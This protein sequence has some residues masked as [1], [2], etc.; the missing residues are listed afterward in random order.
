MNNYE[1]YFRA[2]VSEKQKSGQTPNGTCQKISEKRYQC[3]PL[4]SENKLLEKK[5]ALT[6]A[7]RDTAIQPLLMDVGK[8]RKTL[9]FW[10]DERALTWPDTGNFCAYFREYVNRYYLVTFQFYSVIRSLLCVFFLSRAL[11]LRQHKGKLHVRVPW[12]LKFW[13]ERDAKYLQ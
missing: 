6:A 4:L 11:F 7:R 3:F 8:K 12:F 5:L 1:I 13:A 9:V 2:M 10:P